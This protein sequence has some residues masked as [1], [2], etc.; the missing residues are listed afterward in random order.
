MH[1]HHLVLELE[2]SLSCYFD[3]IRPSLRLCDPLYWQIWKVPLQNFTSHKVAGIMKAHCYCL[4]PFTMQPTVPAEVLSVDF[5]HNEK[6]PR[7]CYL[8]YL[9]AFL[10]LVYFPLKVKYVWEVRSISIWKPKACLLFPK[11]RSKKWISLCP[12]SIPEAYR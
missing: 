3:S 7:G 9:T 2:F 1:L 6:T 4:W 11:E 10:I 5:L 12:Y 8:S